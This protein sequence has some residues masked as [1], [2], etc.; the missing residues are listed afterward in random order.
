MVHAWDVDQLTQADDPAW[1]ELLQLIAEAP[2]P[3]HVLDADPDA[4]RRVV[5]VLQVRS[6]SFLG[7]MALHT[8]ALV[9]DHGWFRLLGCG[10]P[11]LRDLASANHLHGPLTDATMP[12]LL[13]FCVDA[14][15]GRF[16]I[17]TGG[18]RSR[19]GEVCYFG[20]D[21]L[22]WDGIG[23][24]HADFVRGVL[25]G[26]M[27]DDFASLRWPGWEQEVDA[28]PLDVGLASDPPPFVT[29]RAGNHDRVT[30]WA[31]PL[32][33]LHAFYDEAARALG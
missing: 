29:M 14:V 7:A 31:M 8:G 25:R 10:A 27:G 4:A 19:L 15:G 21:T 3:V 20:P 11:H 18:L 33:E 2:A 22:S 26:T 6:S 30:R 1:Q 9:A 5:H 16:A 12:P 13:L 32:A 28:L 17:N 24:R 23:V